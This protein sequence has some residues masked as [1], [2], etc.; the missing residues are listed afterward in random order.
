MNRQVIVGTAGVATATIILLAVFIMPFP[1]PE[2]Q[3]VK[4]RFEEPHMR[5][6]LDFWMDVHVTNSNDTPMRL[7]GLDM[8]FTDKS[9]NTVI[10][11]DLRGNY[12]IAP[13]A[14]I[15]LP[16]DIHVNPEVVLGD[17]EPGEVFG[18][19]HI[20]TPDGTIILPFDAWPVE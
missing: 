3:A 9:G 18:R 8:R 11:G 4:V 13:G 14:T 17:V 6:L 2:T 7:A 16:M 15:T 1:A 5:G 19:A 12:R 10:T 20:D